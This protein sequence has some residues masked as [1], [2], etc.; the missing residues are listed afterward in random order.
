MKFKVASSKQTIPK[1]DDMTRTIPPG[2]QLLLTSEVLLRLR[3]KKTKLHDLQNPESKY[4]DSSFPVKRYL[5][6]GRNPVWVEAEI[7]AWI[8]S[9]A[10]QRREPATPQPSELLAPSVT[11]AA[12]KPKGGARLI[13]RW[14]LPDA[15]RTPRVTRYTLTPKFPQPGI[16][17]VADFAA[18]EGTST[19]PDFPLLN[20]LSRQ[21]SCASAVEGDATLRTQVNGRLEEA[22]GA[23]TNRPPS[24]L[25]GA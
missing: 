23:P 15:P 1:G 13:N 25:R 18:G 20:E 9:S 17:A 3:F 16:T 7:D 6:K 8:A 10:R 5:G 2:A 12:V 24:L 11:N 14:G 19:S 4:H 21:P 22:V